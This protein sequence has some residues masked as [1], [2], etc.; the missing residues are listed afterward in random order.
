MASTASPSTSARARLRALVLD[1]IPYVIL[2]AYVGQ[3]ADLVS[4]IIMLL[5][6]ELWLNLL[7]CTVERS[8]SEARDMYF[9]WRG[10]VRIGPF[11]LAVNFCPVVRVVG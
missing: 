4:G 11:W 2:F 10:V 6:G 7:K 3:C 9:I 1:I 5:P 8:I